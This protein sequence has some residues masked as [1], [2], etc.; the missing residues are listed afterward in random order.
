MIHDCLHFAM[1]KSRHCSSL[2]RRAGG[3]SR[4]ALMNSSE[5]DAARAG[6]S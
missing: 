5:I 3:G 6:G 2:R 4:T 1:D